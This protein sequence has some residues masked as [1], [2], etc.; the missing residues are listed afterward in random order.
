MK[1]VDSLLFSLLILQAASDSQGRIWR[2]HPTHLYAIEV[3]ILKVITL[4]CM[5]LFYALQEEE[6]YAK[7]SV[8]LLSLLPTIECHSPNNVLHILK[9]AREG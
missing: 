9:N 6:V 4:I 2:C 5:A 1:Q 3:T 7:S 8:T